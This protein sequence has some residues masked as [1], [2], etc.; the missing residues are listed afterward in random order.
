MNFVL[1]SLLTSYNL[2]HMQTP[3]P[4]PQEAARLEELHSFDILDSL[5]EEDYDQLTAIAAQICG[6]SISLVTLI[7]QSRQWFKSHHGLDIS[8]TPKEYA[9]CA[10]AIHYNQLFV[11]E[12]ARLDER[13]RDNPL[14]THEPHVIFYAGVPL[15]TEK[16][17][18]LGTLCVIDTQ[19]RQL[20]VEQITAL[21]GLANQIMNLLKLR[22]TKQLLEITTQK[23]E[24]ENQKIE[25][26][27]YTAAHDL[28][29]PLNQIQSLAMLLNDPTIPT[30]D[31][32]QKQM[33]QLIVNSAKRL[34]QFIEDLLFYSKLE[35]Q[36]K[37]P[38]ESIYLPEF[39]EELKELIGNN[40][41]EIHT[42]FS[43]ETIMV[44]PF[45]LRQILLNLFSNAIKYN[46]SPIA[47]I[48]V[49][50]EELETMY[51]FFV[52]DNGIGIAPEHQETIFSE[53]TTLGRNDRFG[54]K[55]AA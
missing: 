50:A 17:L 25:R 19:P 16:G 49:G 3:K 13:F 36:S 7:D 2:F 37:A 24:Q 43:V 12:D 44:N 40:S 21:K 14:V 11:V 39:M 23:L 1:R 52:K 47:H 42:R 54:K 29:T 10:H 6:V 51:Q 41:H 38:K 26:F 31:E 48:E 35:T 9:F 46:Y 4:H 34:S 53:F 8:E 32:E 5:P 33:L 55:A 22:K 45:V 27:S 15:V 28:K 18:P 30:S 20:N